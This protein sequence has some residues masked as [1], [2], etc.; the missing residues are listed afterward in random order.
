MNY[1]EN[2]NKYLAEEK[3]KF[4]ALVADESR[5]KEKEVDKFLAKNALSDQQGWRVNLIELIAAKLPNDVAVEAIR[6]GLGE[7]YMQQNAQSVLSDK[8]KFFVSKQFVTDRFDEMLAS[9]ASRVDEA[10]FEEVFNEAKAYVTPR[11][12]NTIQYPMRERVNALKEQVSSSERAAEEK[13][14]LTSIL[15]HANEIMRQGDEEEAQAKSAYSLGISQAVY[16]ESKKIL[17]KAI[18]N[19]EA[20]GVLRNDNTFII[21]NSLCG[22]PDAVEIIKEQKVRLAESDK[23]HYL[24]IFKTMQEQGLLRPENPIQGEEG[25]K[26]YAFRNIMD[27]RYAVKK[28]LEAGDFEAIKTASEEYEKHMD[29]MREVYRVAAEELGEELNGFPDNVDN[30][31]NHEIPIEFKEHYKLN[32]AI[33]GLYL[34]MELARD[35]NVSIEELLDD[36]AKVSLDYIKR[37]SENYTLEAFAKGRT[38]GQMFAYVSNLDPRT[39]G[40]HAPCHLAT[41]PIEALNILSQD[42]S[43][44]EKNL[45]AEHMVG[46]LC[47]EYDNEFKRTLKFFNDDLNKSVVNMFLMGE[48][49]MR[50][51]G[52]MSR[53]GYYDRNTLEHIPG[54]TSQDYILSHPQDPKKLKKYIETTILEYTQGAKNANPVTTKTLIDGARAAI[55]EAVIFSNMDLKSPEAAALLNFYKDPKKELIAAGVDPTKLKMKIPDKEYQHIIRSDKRLTKQANARISY[56]KKIVR[57][58]EKYNKKASKLEKKIADTEAKIAN[59][60]DDKAKEKLT[61]SKNALEQKLGT[62]KDKELNR[63]NT[64]RTAGKLTDVYYQRRTGDIKE[65]TYKNKRDLYNDTVRIDKK[66]FVAKEIENGVSAKEANQKYAEVEAKNKLEAR[67]AVARRSFAL[68][69]KKIDLTKSPDPYK[70]REVNEAKDTVQKQDTQ[71][72]QAVVKQLDLSDKI[73]KPVTVEVTKEKQPEVVERDVKKEMEE[74]TR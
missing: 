34:T 43:A 62:L 40:K 68:E 59:G 16:R 30:Q 1:Q 4:D 42:P 55:Y 41:R 6:Q 50:N 48:D 56:D 25:N 26:T 2:I 70:P 36:P 44:K 15:E 58:E 8:F 32:A 69:E 12:R 51:P 72:K 52:I 23:A 74:Q 39:V 38:L 61:R 17:A 14:R 35:A 45:L 63:L 73:R 21:A 71:E 37:D 28:A 66:D 5:P 65:N 27:A 20:H 18:D 49:G 10:T 54:V 29:A 57:A 24:K 60:K 22:K 33:N 47:F 9:F 31:R 53:D 67:N 7:E 19:N 3:R 64:E 11:M 13:E 46:A